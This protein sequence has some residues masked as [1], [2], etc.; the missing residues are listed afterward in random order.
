MGRRM[1]DV[2]A[3]DCG[4]L[5]MRNDKQDRISKPS[6]ASRESAKHPRFSVLRAARP[7]KRLRIGKPFAAGVSAGHSYLQHLSMVRY[8]P[9]GRYLFEQRPPWLNRL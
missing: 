9:N 5:R 4:G 2:R 1:A 7:R 3:K 6:Q 8:R